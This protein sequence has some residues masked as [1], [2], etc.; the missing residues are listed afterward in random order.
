MDKK[1]AQNV[2]LGVFVLIACIGF[3]FV[4]FTIGDGGGFLTRQV[5]FSSRFADVKGL[6]YGSEVSLSGLHV[7]VVKSITVSN[8]NGKELTVMFG[9]DK[10]HRQFIRKDSTAIVKT[11]GVLGDRYVEISI[12]SPDSPLLE[13]GGELP[14][15][16]ESDILSKGGNLMEDI[17]KH[18][19]KGGDIEALI[20]NLN[21]I[22][23]NL[24]VVTSEMQKSK[25]SLYHEAFYGSSGDKLNKSMAHVESILG[26]INKGE[27][28]LGALINDPTVYED[29][30]NLLGGA[31]RSSVLKYFMRSFIEDGEKT[32]K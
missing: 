24:A 8:K 14:A 4:I 26:K 22:A 21:K 17:S 11:Q 19:D 1:I 20:K 27:G 31:K 3:V 23:I 28:T 7:G 10:E 30:K 2:I 15:S 12:G 32:K 13:D 16:E 29:I 9:I 5:N 25:S 18:F 6:H